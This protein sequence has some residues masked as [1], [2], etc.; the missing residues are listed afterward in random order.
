MPPGLPVPPSVQKSQH[1]IDMNGSLVD[2]MAQTGVSVHQDRMPRNKRHRPHTH[3]TLLRRRSSGYLHSCITCLT[4]PG[5][6]RS[7]FVQ[8]QNTGIIYRYFFNIELYNI[9]VCIFIPIR[10]S[11]E[12]SL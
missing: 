8:M 10:L 7:Y 3:G 4:L 12:T 6:L 1:E 9:Y 11:S 2:K 5:L